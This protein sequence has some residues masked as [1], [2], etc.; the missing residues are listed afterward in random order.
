MTVI[1]SNDNYTSVPRSEGKVS[2]YTVAH[3]STFHFS[4]YT[5]T[6]EQSQSTVWLVHTSILIDFYVQEMGNEKMYKVKYC[7]QQISLNIWALSFRCTF[8]AVVRFF[9]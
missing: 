7:I 5:G 4:G 3:C 2:K 6:T 1:T 9:Q 8:H